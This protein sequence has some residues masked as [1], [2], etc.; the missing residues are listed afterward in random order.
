M[1]DRLAGRSVLVV[2]L[3]A[4]AFGVEEA[5]IVLYLRQ[6]PPYG[7]AIAAGTTGVDLI[8]Y[9]NHLEV[10]RE[11]CTLVVL[12]AV[13]WLASGL[14]EQRVRFFLV[15]FGVWDIVYYIALLSLS[16]YPGLTSDDVLFLIPIPW[17]GPVWA[18][19]S[20][21]VALTLV[22]LFGTAPR[23]GLVLTAGLVLGWISF[24]IGPFRALYSD[25][26]LDT[27]AVPDIQ[28]PTWLF[29]PAIALVVLSVAR[30]RTAR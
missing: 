15:A 27:S 7:H 21:A 2:T 29:V 16:G 10:A 26:G 20:F 13:A 18:A 25:H 30:Y 6:L 17:I 24:V 14:A 11:L 28:Y 5:I 9:V 1:R 22:G 12:C 23:R 3:F 8:H 4:I 19:I